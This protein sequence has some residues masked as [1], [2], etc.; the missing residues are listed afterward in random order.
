MAEICPA[1]ET[2]DRRT[3]VTTDEIGVE[4]GEETRIDEPIE[5]TA[6][7]VG[8]TEITTDEICA[9]EETRTIEDP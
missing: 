8:P 4:F 3:D 9:T 5:E 6:A 2:A 7:D 1:E